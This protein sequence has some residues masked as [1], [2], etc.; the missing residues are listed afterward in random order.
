[1]NKKRKELSVEE[2]QKISGGFSI[3]IKELEIIVR[4]LYGVTRPP[5]KMIPPIRMLYGVLA[6]VKD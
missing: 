4:P 6:P 2:L 5:I 1:M 3:N